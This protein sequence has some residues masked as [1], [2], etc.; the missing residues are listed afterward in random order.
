MKRII[1]IGLGLLAIIVVIQMWSCQHD[2]LMSDDDSM[3]PIDTMTMDTMTIDT[4]QVDTIPL[5][6][7]CD[8][9]II[10]FSKDVLPLLISNCAFSGC[11]DADSAEDGVILESYEDVIMTADV[12]PFNLDD[13]EIYEVLVDQDEEERMPPAPTERLSAD[14]IQIIA[15]WILQGAEDLNCDPSLTACDSTSVSL[16]NDVQPILNSQCLGCH[17]GAAPSGGIGLD[18]YGLIKN[19]ADNGKLIGAIT[20]SPGFVDMPQGGDKLSDCD[21]AIIQ[22]WIDEGTMDN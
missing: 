15:R 12:E 6:I 21:I 16:A 3:M 1:K 14:Q 5:G 18:S 19:V 7:P 10:Y 8:P 2:P 17:S 20:W 9:D 4:M 11:H 13:S 22:G